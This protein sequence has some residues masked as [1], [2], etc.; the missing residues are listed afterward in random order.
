MKDIVGKEYAPFTIAVEKRWIRSFAEAIGEDNPIHRDEEAAIAAGYRSLPAP[1]TFPFTLAM[2][3][4]QPFLVLEDL[5]IDK[6][7]TMHGEQ[8]FVYHG[9]IVAGDVITGQQ[10]VV[11]MYDKKGGALTFIV[12]ETR[13]ANQRGE[14]VCDLTTTIVVRND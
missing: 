14:R 13:L 5:A 10:K 11:D 6:T 3:A 4:R 9:D 2:E 1:P 8:S 12:T 7:K